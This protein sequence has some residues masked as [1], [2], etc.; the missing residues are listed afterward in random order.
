MLFYVYFSV[1]MFIYVA[2]TANLK[3]DRVQR[4]L[5]TLQII[6]CILERMQP[7]GH[8]IILYFQTGKKNKDNFVYSLRSLSIYQDYIIIIKLL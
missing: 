6:R 5:S 8:F 3:Q 7:F 1:F 2:V 4:F